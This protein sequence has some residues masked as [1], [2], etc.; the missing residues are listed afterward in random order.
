MK[1]TVPMNVKHLLALTA[2]MVMSMWGVTCSS[3][4]MKSP[5]E[6]NVRLEGTGSRCSG[7]LKMLHEGKWKR[8]SSLH[9]S[10]QSTELA[11]QQ[12]H[13]GIPFGT[14]KPFSKEPEKQEVCLECQANSTFKNCIWTESNCTQGVALVCQDPIQMSTVQ[15]ESTTTTLMTTSKPTDAPVIR[16][17]DG[18]AL[19]S[20]AVEL[21]FGS[22]QGL[23]KELA[24]RVCQGEGCEDATEPKDLDNNKPLRAHWEKMQC[25]R[26][27]LSL[28]CLE[29]TKACFTLVKCSGQ[30]FKNKASS[31]EITLGILLGLVLTTFLLINCVPPIY[32]K[33]MKKYFKKR[34]HQWIGP[35]AVN[36]NVSF[37]R[38]SSASFHPHQGQIVQEEDNRTSKKTYLS[39]Y[40]A[41]EGATIR[42]SNP[43]DNS[44]DSD[45]DL[46]SAQ[47][48]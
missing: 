16:L 14:L 18:T 34:Q 40:A 38:N 1:R 48:L 9:W 24:P 47:Q 22:L 15:P 45:Y 20:G 43:L 8:I 11:C 39:P 6:W 32:K 26:K 44:S 2:V 33:I 41:L 35:N 29:R 10:P 4:E 36:Q 3:K 19:C 25:E 37:H 5:E 7:W 12:L 23:W 27:N 30:D 46:S 13:C 28:D 17:E 42:I 31:T 21:N